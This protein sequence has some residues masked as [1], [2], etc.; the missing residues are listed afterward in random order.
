MGPVML[1]TPAPWQEESRSRNMAQ[2]RAAHLCSCR[3]ELRVLSV[4]IGR[5]AS[6]SKNIP[7]RL[8]ERSVHARASCPWVVDAKLQTSC[9][10]GRSFKAYRSS[11]IVG[12]SK[13]ECSRLLLQAQGTLSFD[14]AQAA[15]LESARGNFFGACMPSGANRCLRAKLM[16][17]QSLLHSSFRPQFSALRS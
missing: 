16:R 15:N 17:T 10:Q 11:W 1:E 2:K 12:R 4:E 13:W 7:G 9:L 6:E 14:D 8:W 3:V 5:R